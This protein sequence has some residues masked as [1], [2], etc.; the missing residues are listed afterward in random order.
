MNHKRPRIIKAIMK[1]NKDGGIMCPNFKLDY[2][3]IVIKTV[4]YWQKNIHRRTKQ[5]KKPRKK[6]MTIWSINIWQQS[7]EYIMGRGQSFQQTILRKPNR[8][9]H[10]KEW[11]C[12]TTL[13]HTH[14]KWTQMD[15][16]L[17][18]NKTWYHKTTGRKYRF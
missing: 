1:K 12:T 4:W 5:N 2:K 14:L 13:Q 11:N 9:P 6:P 18:H 17:E 16:R 3:P 7:Q 8:Q 15:Q 10:A